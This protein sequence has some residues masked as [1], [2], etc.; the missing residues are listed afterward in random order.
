[1]LIPADARFTGF[2][3]GMIGNML[4]LISVVTMRDNWRVGIPAED[5]TDFVSSGIY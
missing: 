4:F 2:C 5:K 1:M 3:I